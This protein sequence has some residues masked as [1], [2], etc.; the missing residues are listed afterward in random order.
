MREI[1]LC[2]LVAF[3]S[4]FIRSVGTYSV[5][6]E[7]KE[8]SIGEIPEWS[9]AY[10]EY[11]DNLEYASEFTYSLIYL[12][13]DTIPEL[14]ITTNCEAG[15][16][17]VATYYDGKVIDLQL[18][19]IGTT[20]IEHSGLLYTNT[21]HMDYYPV[22]ITRLEDGDFQVIAEGVS[23]L[24]EENREIVANGGEYIFTYEWDGTIVSQDEFYS[25][26]EKYYDLDKGIYPEECSKLEI[27]SILTTG[28]WSSYGHSYELVKQDVTW[29]EAA[30]LCKEKGGYLATITCPDE[31]GVIAELIAS[32]NM[33]DTNFYV[34]YRSSEYVGEEYYGAR[35]I[36][37]DGSFTDAMYLVGL[38][39]YYAPDFDS[40]TYDW[41]D[42]N[43]IKTC[44]LVKYYDSNSKIYVFE[45]SGNLIEESPN[46]A[47]TLGYICEFD[48]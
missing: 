7:D 28:F 9:L 18:S 32:K 44:G 20:Y 15:G 47:G 35:W 48:N 38:S 36:N 1:I 26:V 45:E 14:F 12:D 40:E 17:I 25:F 11:I 30:E 4:V 42:E 21:G 13:E 46:V 10:A 5:A 27:D 24:S 22:Y 19:R 3:T 16:E 34:G 29:E 41:S 31:A 6:V 43:E 37:A 33:G 8:S 39:M 2:I 23:Y